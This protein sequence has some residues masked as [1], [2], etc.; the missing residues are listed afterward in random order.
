M[1]QINIESMTIVFKMQ[2]YFLF[3]GHWFIYIY[4]YIYLY[5][6]IQTSNIIGMDNMSDSQFEFEDKYDE[7]FYDDVSADEN[8]QHDS[9]VEEKVAYQNSY[10]TDTD[11]ETFKN[12]T[13]PSRTPPSR[14]PR[15]GNAK[16][17]GRDKKT[18]TRISDP[19]KSYSTPSTRRAQ[20]D[21]RSRKPKSQVKL[22]PGKGMYDI[23][24]F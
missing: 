18:P 2:H 10:E 3:L 20:S 12:K 22:I 24:I 6:C 4:L 21:P 1:L 19:Y 15:R 17:N 9:G 5:I 11:N 8:N 13:V 16:V 23:Y 7:E 14:T